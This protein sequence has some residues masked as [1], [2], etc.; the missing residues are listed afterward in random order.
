MSNTTG[1]QIPD[2]KE[3]ERAF[4][5]LPEQLAIKHLS[6]AVKASL[7]PAM[8]ALRQ[9]V[10][11]GQS[12]SLK[13][14]VASKTK[15][16]KAD[17]TVLGLVGIKM[18]KGDKGSTL[19]QVFQEF[20]TKDRET[21]GDTASS[22]ARK[23]FKI[24][25]PKKG[26]G[27]MGQTY[28]LRPASPYNFYYKNWRGGTVKLGRVK[29]QKYIEGAWAASQGTVKQQLAGELFRRLTK[30]LKEFAYRQTRSDLRF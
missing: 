16:Y 27:T 21:I 4:T 3:L 28:Q 24:F 9:N 6:P 8:H 5:A 15:I 30:A 14:N 23:K 7:E 20:G 22:Y 13:K 26:V 25:L 12:G 2:L 19:H 11:V 18:K 1:L 29:P 17:L 10:A